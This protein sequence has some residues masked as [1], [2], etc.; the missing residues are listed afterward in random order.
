MDYQELIK[1]LRDKAEHNQYKYSDALMIKSADAIEALQADLEGTEIEWNQASGLLDDALR[2]IEILEAELAKYR[3]APVVAYA[4]TN[5]D[6]ELSM[7]F[8]R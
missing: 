7:L 1:K 5:E 3:D 8:L 4:T 6:D 2:S